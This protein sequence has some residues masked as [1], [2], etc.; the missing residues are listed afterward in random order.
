MFA[1]HVSFE[2]ELFFM[3]N[4]LGLLKGLDVFENFIYFSFFGSDILLDL[5]FLIFESLFIFLNQVYLKQIVFLKISQVLQQ[6]MR[7]GEINVEVRVF[8]GTKH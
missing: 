6:S 2:E 5:L 1:L 3:K 4:G 7:R 8:V